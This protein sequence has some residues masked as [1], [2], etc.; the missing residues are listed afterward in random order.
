MSDVAEKENFPM[1]LVLHAQW[2]IIGFMLK[3]KSWL[4]TSGKTGKA[5]AEHLGVPQSFVSKIANG[6]KP[7]PVD[8]MAQIEVFTS[9]E[10]TRQDMCP[11][12]WHLIWP[13]LASEN[14]QKT[15]SA[16]TAKTHAAINSQEVA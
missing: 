13:E 7:I 4:K 2:A 9:G 3:L 11:D 8:R 1:G 16:L 6:D 12:R 5:L 14:T 10:V 15:A